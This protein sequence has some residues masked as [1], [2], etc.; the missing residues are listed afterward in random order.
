MLYNKQME[1]IIG[2]ILILGTFLSALLVMIGG[3]IYLWQHGSENFQVELLQA[4]YYQL[5]VSEILRGVFSLSPVGLIELG[6]I[7]LIVTQILR[8]A[9]LVGFYAMIKDYWFT[10]ISLFIL[11]VLLYSFFW[12]N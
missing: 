6:L 11:F 4:N 8:V 1:N 10:A 5:N 7:S 2:W 9:L 12:R 3:S